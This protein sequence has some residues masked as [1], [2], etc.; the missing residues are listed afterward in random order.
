MVND[1]V[2][3]A[4]FSELFA[5]GTALRRRRSPGASVP[6]PLACS[7]GNSTKRERA[8]RR[9]SEAPS[10]TAVSQEPVTVEWAAKLATAETY[11]EGEWSN[12]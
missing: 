4:R 11:S 3:L 6:T 9:V 7:A 10:S 1:D 12:V 8:P 2:N 5:P